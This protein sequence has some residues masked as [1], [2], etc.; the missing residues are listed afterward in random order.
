MIEKYKNAKIQSWLLLS[1]SIISTILTIISF[2]FLFKSL[3]EIGNSEVKDEKSLVESIVNSLSK[4]NIFW[5]P[6]AIL[7]LVSLV[8]T[9][10]L[11]LF[12][13][14]KQKLKTIFVFLIIGIFIGVFEVVAAIMLIIELPKLIKEEELDMQKQKEQILNVETIVE[15]E[16]QE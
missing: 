12:T 4:I 15:E 3:I 10:M 14:G 13:N 6:Q 5:I 11:I 7:S 1:I 9:I 16:K 8:L 2:S